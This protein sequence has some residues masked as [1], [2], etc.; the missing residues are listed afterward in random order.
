MCQSFLVP[1]STLHARPSLHACHK[2]KTT[3]A[4]DALANMYE[5]FKDTMKKIEHE[6]AEGDM[7]FAVAYEA[8]DELEK[9]QKVQAHLQ[10]GLRATRESLDVGKFGWCLQGTQQSSSPPRRHV[11]RSGR[12]KSKDRRVEKES[13]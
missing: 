2:K 9:A 11:C 12:R 8:M 6:T 10:D 7:F 3:Q 13:R 1:S 5:N 4:S